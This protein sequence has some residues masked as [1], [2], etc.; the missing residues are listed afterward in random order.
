[1]KRLILILL[2]LHGFC[3][4]TAVA[5]DYL[6][7]VDTVGYPDTPKSD[8]DPEDRILFRMETI[9]QLGTVFHSEVRI[10]MHTLLLD[11]ELHPTDDGN[12]K[13]TIRYLDIMETTVPTE[14]GG[15]QLREDKS[16]A[17]T[18]VTVS[19]GVPVVLGGLRTEKTQTTDA[20]ET[21]TVSK[22]DYVLNVTAYSNPQTPTERTS[23]PIRSLRSCRHSYASRNGCD[24][25][26]LNRPTHS[27]GCS[28]N[29][30]R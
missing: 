9:V 2:S 13:V 7:R 23:K 21:T 10:G 3:A 18:T 19:L 28:T 14:S 20:G 6:L 25:F 27:H 8:K 11:G 24:K 4:A 26:V 17:S 1:M 30:P 16:E 5:G 29:S 15:V 12:F 22:T